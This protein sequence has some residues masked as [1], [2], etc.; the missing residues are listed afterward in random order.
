[1]DNYFVGCEPVNDIDMFY[2]RSEKNIDD[3]DITYDLEI[4]LS[5]YHG[6]LENYGAIYPE[7]YDP[8]FRTYEDAQNCID[9]L[10]KDTYKEDYKCICEYESCDVISLLKNKIGLSKNELFAYDGEYVIRNINVNYCPKCGRE[11]I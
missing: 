5:K 9:Y 10:N 8:M 6:I 3:D 11:L 7:G 4:S 2:I 1:M